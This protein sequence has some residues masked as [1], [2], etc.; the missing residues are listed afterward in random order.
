MLAW[1]MGAPSYQGSWHLVDIYTKYLFPEKIDYVG[2]RPGYLRGLTQ[3]F[4]YV[5]PKPSWPSLK[6]Q[7]QVM[8]KK[9]LPPPLSVMAPWYFLSFEQKLIP[10]PSGLLTD[11]LTHFSHKVLKN[12]AK[13]K[14]ILWP[15]SFKVSGNKFVNAP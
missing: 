12:L 1:R 5:L 9:L 6:E 10:L 11:S 8:T 14:I 15:N 4:F 3:F 7:K 13:V 2:K